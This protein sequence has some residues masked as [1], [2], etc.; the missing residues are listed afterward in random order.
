M[1]K[2]RVALFAALVFIF[3]AVSIAVAAEQA[4]WEMRSERDLN[5]LFKILS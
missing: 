3:V 2:N 1:M 4:P 5:T